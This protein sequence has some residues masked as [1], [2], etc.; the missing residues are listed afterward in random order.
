MSFEVEVKY[1][2]VDHD[3]LVQRLLEQGASAGTCAT[4]RMFT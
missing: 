3:H 4:T 2:A 1:R